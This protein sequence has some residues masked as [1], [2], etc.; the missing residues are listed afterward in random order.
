MK[1]YNLVTYNTLYNQEKFR[2]LFFK[3]I[4]MKYEKYIQNEVNKLVETFYTDEYMQL[5]YPEK[6]T[7]DDYALNINSLIF[8][9]FSELTYS[10]NKEYYIYE[11][12]LFNTTNGYEKSIKFS[13]LF[14]PKYFNKGVNDKSVKA[15]LESFTEPIYDMLK[16]ISE[17]TL[18][19]LESLLDAFKCNPN[20]CTTYTK[21]KITEVCSE[22]VDTK[23][24]LYDDEGE[25]YLSICDKLKIKDLKETFKLYQNM[26]NLDTIN[27]KLYMFVSSSK[28]V[29]IVND[30]SIQDEIHLNLNLNDGVSTVFSSDNESISEN[31]PLMCYLMDFSLCE[32]EELELLLQNIYIENCKITILN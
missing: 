25:E 6:E 7:F 32:V 29:N 2:N 3:Y 18:K 11:G 14:T 10:E 22:Y 31:I 1:E 28:R 17:P 30:K 8:C 5:S 4:N 13:N 26:A 9:N 20:L 27:E 21:L 15:V 24:T 23:F 12:L 19:A 16:E